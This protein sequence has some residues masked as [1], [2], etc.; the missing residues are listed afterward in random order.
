MDLFAPA[1]V[2]DATISPC[3]KYRYRLTRTWSGEHAL[4][5]IMLNPSTADA[6]NDD[7]TIRRCMGFARDRGFGG[8]IVANL[9]AFRATSP[10]DMKAEHFP[11]G[12]MG[13]NAITDLMHW[14]KRAGVPVVAAWGTHG[15]FRNRA[16]QVAS[17]AR[18]IGCEIVCLGATKG[19]HPRHPLYV[20]SDQ[21]FEPF[22]AQVDTHPEGGDCLQAPF[23]GSAVAKPCAPKAPE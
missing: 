20:R 19:G 12:A 23:M 7:P 4:P 11:V 16:E 3:G 8:I 6:S 21:P 5:F 9:F 14:A 15:T 2:A 10:A 22:P 18:L 1:V 17:F 13:D